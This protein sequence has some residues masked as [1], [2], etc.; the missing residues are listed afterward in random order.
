[1]QH[2]VD[3]SAENLKILVIVYHTAYLNLILPLGLSWLHL[4]SLHV[5]LAVSLQFVTPIVA[6]FLVRVCSV[7]LH[8]MPY[9]VALFLVQPFQCSICFDIH[10]YTAHQFGSQLINGVYYFLFIL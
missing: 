5:L 10:G 6:S 9:F 7:L 2:L 8:F 3:Y 4:Y 1:M